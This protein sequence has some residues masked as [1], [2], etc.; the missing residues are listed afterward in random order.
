MP[1]KLWQ[2]PVRSRD[3][4]ESCSVLEREQS[5]T[6]AKNKNKTRI[7]HIASRKECFIQKYVRRIKLKKVTLKE[8][9]RRDL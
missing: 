2:S 1:R 3:Q 9:M 4:C 6:K 8:T 7:L 5:Q